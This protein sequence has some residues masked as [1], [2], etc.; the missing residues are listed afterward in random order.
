MSIFPQAHGVVNPSDAAL[1]LPLSLFGPGFP[2]IEMD[3]LLVVDGRGRLAVRDPIKSAAAPEEPTQQDR[4]TGPND[5]DNGDAQQDLSAVF[6]TSDGTG[7]GIA[8]R[9]AS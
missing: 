3:E 6:A 5:G 1:G 8:V 9:S 4:C 2:Q 7:S